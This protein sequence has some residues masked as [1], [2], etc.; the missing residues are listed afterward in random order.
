MS[1]SRQI[2]VISLA[3]VLFV[4]KDSEN[5][6]AL[7]EDVTGQRHCSIPSLAV[8]TPAVQVRLG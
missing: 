2:L 3:E 4:L 6:Q 7:Q 8:Y 1:H 5:S